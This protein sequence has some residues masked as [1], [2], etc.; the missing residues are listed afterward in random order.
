MNGY[1]EVGESRCSVSTRQGMY[2]Q[3][4]IQLS[5]LLSRSYVRATHTN[6][7]GDNGHAQALTHSYP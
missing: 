4:L 6:A 5:A 1:L 2:A 7:L 3:S